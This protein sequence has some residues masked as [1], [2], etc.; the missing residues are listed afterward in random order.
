MGRTLTES[1]SDSGGER[2]A[3]ERV[4]QRSP[5]TAAA[6]EIKDGKGRIDTMRGAA[7][8]K[9][10]DL[11]NRCVL[12]ARIDALLLE[13]G[14]HVLAACPVFETLEV[15]METRPHIGALLVDDDFSA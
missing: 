4:V 2:L 12:E 5:L 6:Y 8:I 1:N 15:T 13:L 11:V 9:A 7:R 3:L 10:D 14:K